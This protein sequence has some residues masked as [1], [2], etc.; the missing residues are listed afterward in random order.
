MLYHEVLMLSQQALFQV[1]KPGLTQCGCR[2][3]VE[4]Q[5]LLYESIVL[6]LK[7]KTHY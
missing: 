6:R 4:F 2:N 5:L 1:S 7:A 3:I